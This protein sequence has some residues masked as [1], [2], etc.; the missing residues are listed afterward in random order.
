MSY[1]AVQTRRF[2][3]QYKKL[4][5]NVAADVDAAVS[6]VVTSPKIGDQKKGDCGF[7]RSP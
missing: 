4:H 3:L 2:A 6:V 7:H 1:Q 5:D